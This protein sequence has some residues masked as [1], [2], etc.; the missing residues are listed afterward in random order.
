[1]NSKT[2]NKNDDS[3]KDIN[4]SNSYNETSQFIMNKKYLRPLSQITENIYLGN[5]YDAF[6]EK[7][8]LNI[9]IKKILSLIADPQLLKY[10]EKKFVH[11]LIKIDDLPRENI[12]KYFGEC[13]LFIDD[14][15]KVLV[16]CFAGSSRSA[17][18]IMAYLMWKKQLD[19]IECFNIL[20]KIRPS[21]YPNYG[22]VRQLKIFDKL[23]K[24][25]KYNIATINFAA[26]KYPR[27]FEE[28][29]F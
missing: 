9:G 19:Y 24:E 21:V 4:T 25:N 11:K 6:N 2:N 29:C 1:M 8:L 3:K 15:K 16:H 10:D 28:C 26:I 18:I 20:Q 7:N 22:F 5:I 23:L 12:I 14:D 17:T 27:F 13:L